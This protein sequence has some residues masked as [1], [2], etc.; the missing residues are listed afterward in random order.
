[1]ISGKTDLFYAT[2][3]QVFEQ[4]VETNSDVELNNEYA[5]IGQE[6]EFYQNVEIGYFKEAIS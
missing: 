5:F 2:P 4:L 1:M 3:K 6:R